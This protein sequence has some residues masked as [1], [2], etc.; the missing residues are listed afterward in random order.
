[1]GFLATTDVGRAVP[2]AKED[3]EGLQFTTFPEDESDA[4]R[5]KLNESLGQISRLGLVTLFQDRGWGCVCVNFLSFLFF[6]FIW[7]SFIKTTF[8]GVV[9]G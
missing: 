5:R 2:P 4:R 6:S 8:G 1:M 3:D 9:K 7:L